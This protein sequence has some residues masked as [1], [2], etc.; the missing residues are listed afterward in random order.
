MHEY[1]PGAG[2]ARQP[3]QG[4]VGSP[5]A[6]GFSCVGNLRGVQTFFLIK[7]D[8]WTYSSIQRRSC[9]QTEQLYREIRQMAIRRVFVDKRNAEFK[10]SSVEFD[11]RPPHDET[12]IPFF[13][14]FHGPKAITRENTHAHPTPD[15]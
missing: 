15:R 4:D 7:S 1:K 9:G 12:L 10:R 3:K 8:F 14:S 6:S 2:F 11:A 5:S 13:Q